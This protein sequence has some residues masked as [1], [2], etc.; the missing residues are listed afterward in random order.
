MGY[1]A[2]PDVQTNTI[3]SM[4]SSVLF[5]S[6]RNM[7]YLVDLGRVRALGVSNFGIQV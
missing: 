1:T 4:S 6:A 7:E 2:I 3:F 5:A